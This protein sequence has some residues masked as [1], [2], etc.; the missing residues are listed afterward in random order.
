[1]KRAKILSASAGSGKTYQLTLKY[2]CDIIEH[3]D[4][5]RNI[6]AV[7][8]TNKATEEM[9]SRILKE[10]HKLA[11]GA[12]STYLDNII[13]ITS[14]SESQIRKQTKI[15][16]TKI[17]HDYSR[18]SVLTIDRF[19][20]RILRAFIRELSLD[21]NYNIELN[22]QLLLE[23]SA[24]N[25]IERIS[26]DKEVRQ[27]LL[28]Y[29]EERINDDTPWD[30]RRD[31]CQLGE[32]LFKENGAKRMNKGLSKKNLRANV[33]KII[34]ISERSKA[35]IKQL[36]LD[37][38]KY[39][40]DNGLSPDMFKGKSRSFVYSIYPYA[41]GVLKSPSDTMVKAANNPEE[42]YGKDGD[43][44]IKQAANTLQPLLNKLCTTYTNSIEVINNAK[45]LKQNYRSFALLADMQDSVGD[46][47][48]REN[49]MILDNTKDILSKFVDD[50]NTPFIYEKIGNRYDH[51]MIDEFQDTSIRE[52]RNL[53]P[54]LKEALDSNANAS[55]FIVGDIKQSIYRFKGGD[56]RLLSNYAMADLG[57]LN[58]QID[59]LD[60]NY[61]SL[62]NIV[63]FNR[64]FIDRV[65]AIENHYLNTTLDEALKDKKIE[66]LTHDS[67]YDI[68]LTAYADHKQKTAPDNDNGTGYVEVGVFDPKYTSSPFIAAIEDAISRGYRYCDILI[69]V[70]T[71]TE[72]YRAAEALFEYKEQLIAR[73][74]PGFNILTPAALTLENSD[75]TEFIIAVLRLSLNPKNDIERGIYNRYLNLGFNHRFTN[76]ELSRLKRIS[77]LSPMEAIEVIIR[78]FRL[79][80][81]AEHIAY[82]QAMHEQVVGFTSTHPADIQQYLKWWN[83]RGKDETIT[84]EMSDDT[85]EITTVHKSKGLER[86]IIIIPNGKW[87]MTPSA[88]ST[89]VWASDQKNNQGL[90]DIGCFP[91]SYGS[92]MKESSF[93][94]DY[95]KELVMSHIDGLNLLYVALTRA[96]REL[97]VYVPN[98]LNKKSKGSNSEGIS[99]TAPL[100]CTAIEQVTT[101]SDSVCSDDGANTLSTYYRYGNKTTPAAP[102]S[103]REKVAT[104]LTQY[105]S[106]SPNIKVRY[107]SHVVTN[108]DNG[109]DMQTLR[110]GI[111][112][113]KVLEGAKSIDDLHRSIEVMQR[114]CILDAK[115]AQKIRANIDKAMHN[116]AANSW[117]SEEWDDVR[118][119][120]DI[121]TPDGVKRPDRVM[122]A[123]DRIVVVDY[124]FGNKRSVD[125][126]NQIKSY[127]ATFESMNRYRVI[128]GYVWYVSLGEII[129]VTATEA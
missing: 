105:V 104:R 76:E 112:L 44:N 16:R 40:Q 95:Y 38:T 125:H 52:W 24:D 82:L 29:A 89:I 21:L 15:A 92:S 68:T 97:Y 46:I 45:L 77:H 5:Y 13:A 94:D 62:S 129:Q 53:L 1:M 101:L 33:A 85:I 117:F 115:Y 126:I 118:C 49:I 56:W 39:I 17:L 36:A 91:I 123:E 35:T 80:Q 25:L 66:Q 127:M 61:R 10:I 59:H 27:W 103:K 69:L 109:A 108:D 96:A 93:S 65:V 64:K 99:S 22:T 72:G 98:S 75:V 6:L 14:L 42:W 67:L 63:D 58:T 9:K 54:L 2:M 116:T 107:P 73:G 106:N 11:S 4:R 87:S 110:L 78:D 18:F 83:E 100:I 84:V 3:P 71:A 70:R 41:N 47:C 37:I 60:T 50:S 102:D 119:E 34:E 43:A 55:V 26:S 120:A 20:Q 48:K 79:N 30:M 57:E 90:A 12:N 124:K 23:R 19:F 86:D 8:F 128:E 114:R 88:T 113:H 81:T 28:E 7:T 74:K 121:I 51:Y 31:L 122:I 32:E 111:H